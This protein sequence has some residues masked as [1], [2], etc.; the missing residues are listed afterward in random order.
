[1]EV[2]FCRSRLHSSPSVPVMEWRRARRGAPPPSAPDDG[3][4]GLF[5]DPEA[6]GDVEDPINP[7]RLSKRPRA[8]LYVLWLSCSGNGG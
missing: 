3:V 2:G 4:M 1:M 6:A 5:E 8:P 7:S